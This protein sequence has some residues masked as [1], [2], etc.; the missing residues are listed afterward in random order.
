MKK[1]LLTLPVIF[2]C[3]AAFAQNIPPVDGVRM[4]TDQDYRNADSL[5]M[6]VSRYLLSIPL[7][8]DNHT[9][10]RTGL[11][12]TRWMQGS[13]QFNV[14]PNDR[15]LK[16]IDS[17]V[18]LLSV[19]YAAL[20]SFVLK[21]PSVT[22]SNTV[23]LN[24]AKELVAYMDKSSNHVILTRRL[25]KLCDADDKGELKNLLKL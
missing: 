9:R 2:M 10:L 7:N 6:Q 25:K 17:D 5:V 3:M 12:L 24:A 8:N 4:E 14:A 19:Y 18:D 20:C 1:A 22:D 16:Y 15:V 11:F 23:T 21:Y 13:P